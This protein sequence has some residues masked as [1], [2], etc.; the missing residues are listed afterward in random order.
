FPGA[1]SAAVFNAILNQEP[2]LASRINPAT[3]DDLDRIIRKS[4]EKDR[5]VRYQSAA[6]MRADLK[7]LRR[8]STSGK[9]PA[10]RLG[11]AEADR[12]GSNAQKVRTQTRRQ[13]AVIWAASG[14]LA[15]AAI[16]L[17][18]LRSP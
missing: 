13:W 18:W 11:P 4:L 1:T 7:R 10:A 16:F 6:E 15:A 14:L 3:P 12:F 2:A 17:V 8:D 9:T 5:E